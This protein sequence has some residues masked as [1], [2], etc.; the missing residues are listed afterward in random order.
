MNGFER[1][2]NELDR[3]ELANII[4]SVHGAADTALAEAIEIMT[5]Y[6]TLNAEDKIELRNF[7]ASLAGD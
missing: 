2:L 6:E 7:I 1:A 3:E 4:R 5:M